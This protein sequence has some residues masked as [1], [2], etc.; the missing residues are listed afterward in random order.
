LEER[1]ELAP[2]VHP[3]DSVTR[4]GPFGHFASLYLCRAGAAEGFWRDFE[5]NLSRLAG[6]QSAGNELLWGASSLRADGVVLRGV[7]KNGRLLARS[8]TAIWEAAKPA[9]CGRVATP[10]RKIY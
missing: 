8:L 9:L 1:W 6:E 3:L 7:A 5:A 4:L 10:P 2:D